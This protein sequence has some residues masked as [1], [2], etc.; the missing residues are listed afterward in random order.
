MGPNS[1][2]RKGKTEKL[3][4]DIEANDKSEFQ[5]NGY[6]WQK[7]F[8]IQTIFK[9][10]VISFNFQGFFSGYQMRLFEKWADEIYE[11]GHNL[12]KVRKN[13][14]LYQLCYQKNHKNHGI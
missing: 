7:V 6:L 2:E 3:M 9:I 13:N 11:K 1:N 5:L 8:K 14:S 10:Y 4:L 12:V